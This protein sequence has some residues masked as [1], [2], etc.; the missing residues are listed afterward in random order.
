MSS[1]K[2]SIEIGAMRGDGHQ[3]AYAGLGRDDRDIGPNPVD[4]FP[5]GAPG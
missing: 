5:R 4:E 2:T 3:S 1:P